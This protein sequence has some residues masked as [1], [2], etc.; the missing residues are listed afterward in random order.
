MNTNPTENFAT[1]EAVL[2][3]LREQ[4]ASAD[5]SWCGDAEKVSMLVQGLE[6][7]TLLM[8]DAGRR[9]QGRPPAA[10]DAAVQSFLEQ[11]E[12]IAHRRAYHLLGASQLSH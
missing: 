10:L 3:A 4:F 12:R 2:L 6:L 1:A 8:R 5:A 9:L 7:T 11:A